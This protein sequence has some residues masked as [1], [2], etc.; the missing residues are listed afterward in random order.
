MHGVP[1]PSGERPVLERHLLDAARW[2]VRYRARKRLRF[3]DG[4]QLGGWRRT[5]RAVERCTRCG[6][7]DP[8][9]RGAT[10]LPEDRSEWCRDP[11]HDGDQPARDEYR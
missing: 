2:I 9:L 1:V 11:W 5:R 6:S 8:Y 4:I 3:W 7:D 10:D